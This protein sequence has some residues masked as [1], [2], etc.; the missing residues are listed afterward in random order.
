MEAG[1]LAF[2]FGLQVDQLDWT[3]LEYC[4]IIFHL[5]FTSY[6]INRLQWHHLEINI[7]NLGHGLPTDQASFYFSII[8]N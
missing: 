5:E 2:G 6:I 4:H 7:V 3:D 1:R 8:T